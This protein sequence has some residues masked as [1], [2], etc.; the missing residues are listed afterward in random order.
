MKGIERKQRLALTILF[1]SVVFC[2]FIMTMFIVGAAIIILIQRGV[3]EHGKDVPRVKHLIINMMTASVLL[4]SVLTTVTSR[5]PLKPVNSFINAMNRLASGDY[6]TRLHF[7]K[8]F[9]KHPTAKELMESFNH[10]AEELERTEMLR[11]DFINNF[12]HEF[13]TPIVSIAGFAK[14]LKQGNL[15]EEQKMDYI[16]I[17]EE[18]SLRLAAMATNVLNLTKVENQ[19]ILTGVSEFNLSEQIRNCVLLLENKW[20]KKNIELDINFDEYIVYANEEMLKEVWINLLD[21][22]IKY[23]D[24]GGTVRIDI[25]EMESRLLVSISDTGEEI[26]EGA[27]ERI[28]RKFYQVD[29]SHSSVGNGIGLAIV[30]KILDLHGGDI[31]VSSGNRKTVFTVSLP[32]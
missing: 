12:S 28:F 2:F 7:G 8:H 19:T 9:D 29:E 10:M 24:D 11:S 18:E 13:K 25:T 23:S 14:L 15:T 17:I 27:K 30:K 1:S 5:I 6:K 21:N 31:T 22:A 32:K 20:S 4:G 3:L 26:P 16:N